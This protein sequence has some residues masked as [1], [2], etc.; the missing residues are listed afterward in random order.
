MLMSVCMADVC[1]GHEWKYV[2]TNL[3]PCPRRGASF[4]MDI[5]MC[6]KRRVHRDVLMCKSWFIYEATVNSWPLAA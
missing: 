2:T 3:S 4:N 6:I 5:D 1:T